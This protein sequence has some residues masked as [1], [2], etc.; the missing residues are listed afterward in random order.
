[1]ITII[2]GS[3]NK[4]S[5]TLSLTNTLIDNTKQSVTRYDPYHLTIES[6]NDCCYCEHKESCN[7]HD[8]MIPIYNELE[9]T[10]TLII[11]SPI[12]FGHFSDQ[13]MKVINRFQKYFNH[14]WIQK[15]ST[16]KIDHLIFVSTAGHSEEMFQGLNVTISILTKL[17]N[18]KTVHKLFIPYS[19]EHFD[20]N[21]YIS[22]INTI[23][24]EAAI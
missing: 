18:A 13:T 1:M 17:F 2:N 5:K 19:E 23:K 21:D 15:K 20:I 11:S 7:K 22:Q 12:Y 10:T 14:K 3:P 6:C 8:D 9:Q 4:F 24:N 16:P